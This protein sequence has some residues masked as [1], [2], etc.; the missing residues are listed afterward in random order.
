MYQSYRDTRDNG[1]DMNKLVFH[2][3]HR[4]YIF[5]DTALPPEKFFK[6]IHAYFPI[7]KKKIRI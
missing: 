2:P 7:V 4:V 1:K 5:N 6:S 3:I